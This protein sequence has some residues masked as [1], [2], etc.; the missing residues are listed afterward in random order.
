MN[1]ETRAKLS[2]M[3]ETGLI[4]Q[5]NFLSFFRKR[6]ASLKELLKTQ[7][8]FSEEKLIKFKCAMFDTWKTYNSI[9]QNDE[10]VILVQL[11]NNCGVMTR[12]E[13]IKNTQ[14]ERRRVTDAI[15]GL[16]EENLVDDIVQQQNEIVVFLNV[17]RFNEVVC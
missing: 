9:F 10:I 17:K 11:M 8:E 1:D 14:L 7:Y 6:N 12:K 3:V 2:K 15:Q 16:K 13:L 5:E 4:T